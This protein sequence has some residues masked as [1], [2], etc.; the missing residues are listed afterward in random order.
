MV[1]EIVALAIVIYVVLLRQLRFGVVGGGREEKPLFGAPRAA[2]GCAG[3]GSAGLFS[4]VQRR[5]LRLLSRDRA[6]MAQTLLLPAIMV[7]AQVFINAR[8]DVFVGA[9]EHPETLAAIAFGL[10]AYTLML[11]AFQTVTNAEG[12]GFVWLLYSVPQS[13]E[14]ILREKAALWAVA[15]TAYPLPSSSRSPLAPPAMSRRNSSTTTAVVFLGPPIFAVIASALGR[16]RQRPAGARDPT[17]R[18]PDLHLSLYGSGFVLRLCGLCQHD[19]AARGRGDPDCAVGARAYGKRR[20]TNSTIFST[21]PPRRRRAYR[22]Q[23]A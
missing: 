15:A 10:A 20:A 19:M 1:G 9:V 14:K 7:G 11:S 22:P 3:S 12:Q 13:L 6:F 2:A 4:A 21:R 23:T 17:P 8:A 18:P 5:E 16:L